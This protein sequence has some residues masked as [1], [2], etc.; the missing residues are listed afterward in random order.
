MNSSSRVIW[1][2]FLTI[3]PWIGGCGVFLG[4]VKPVAE[5]SESYA[6]M[7]LSEL[8]R[9]WKKLENEEAVSG[10]VSDLA[11][12]SDE[13][14]SI[15]SLNSACRE[16][17][18]NQNDDL[19][20]FTHQLLLGISDIHERRQENVRLE[21]KSALRTTLEGR[22]QGEAVKLRTYVMKSDECLYDLMY[23]ARPETFEVEES[24]FV[25]FVD[26]LRLK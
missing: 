13:T 4:N 21:G 11:Y 26:S 8:S 1:I 5:K 16:G 25:R 10:D 2:F 3:L 24:T 6:V 12:Q 17:L 23:I 14:G 22:L 7:D 19:K 15:I 20:E 18:T 9:K